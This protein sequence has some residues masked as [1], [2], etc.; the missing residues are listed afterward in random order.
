MIN[1]IML[2]SIHRATSI[3]LALLILI[4]APLHLILLASDGSVY[5]QC[6]YFQI[7]LLLLLSYSLWRCQKPSRGKLITMAGLACIITYIN[8]IYLNYGNGLAVWVVP[9][10]GLLVYIA[11]SVMVYRKQRINA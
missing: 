7:S 2:E 4:A 6:V 10:I 3:V 1:P 8:A 5:R 9:S 11:L